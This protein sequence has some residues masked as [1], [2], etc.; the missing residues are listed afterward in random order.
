MKSTVIFIAFSLLLIWVQG[1]AQSESQ[2][3][4]RNFPIVLTLQFHTLSMPFK[5]LKSNF[6][7]IGFGIGTE[8]SHNGFHNWSQQFDIIWIRNRSM[9]NGV[10]FSTQTAWRPMMAGNVYSEIKAGIGY[11]IGFRP[12]ESFSQK[13]GNWISVGKKGKGMLTIPVGIGIGY[14]RYSQGIFLSP[15]LGYQMML[16]KGYNQD[17]PFIPQSLIQVGGKIHSKSFQNQ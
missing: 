6:K 15:Y 10:L 17:I 13:D 9:G 7:N 14:Y 16:V 4:Y 12:T 5:D 8:V 11:M 1:F 2:K 3:N